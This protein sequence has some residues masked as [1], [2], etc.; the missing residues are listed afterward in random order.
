MFF[1]NHKGYNYSIHKLVLLAFV[2]PRPK[3]MDVSHLDGNRKNCIL[4]NLVYESRRD[5]E[6]RKVIHKTLLF[7]ENHP[8]S[9]L[10]N[11]QVKEARRLLESGSLSMSKIGALFGVSKRCISHIKY[12]DTWKQSARAGR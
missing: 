9:K 8:S 4:S 7:G 10:N 6:A 1:R 2:G 3:G 5:N 12:G 11:K